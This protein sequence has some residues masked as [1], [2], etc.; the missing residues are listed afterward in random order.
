M[1]RTWERKVSRST[2]AETIVPFSNNSVQREN[3][4]LVVTMVLERSL[5]S[6]MTL[7]SNSDSYLFETHVTEFIQDQ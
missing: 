6:E 2:R 3:G 4:R 7:N 5:R 1:S